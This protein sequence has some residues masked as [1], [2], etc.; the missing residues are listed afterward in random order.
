MLA[1]ISQ[2]ILYEHFDVAGV[3][4]PILLGN[5][6]IAM[7]CVNDFVAKSVVLKYRRSKLF[8]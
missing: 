6:L 1:N 5:S 7:K 8:V 3:L 4:L 2:A